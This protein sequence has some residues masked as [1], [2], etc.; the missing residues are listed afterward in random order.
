MLTGTAAPQTPAIAGDALNASNR[1]RPTGMA[2]PLGGQEWWRAPGGRDWSGGGVLGRRR[3]LLVATA[4]G[5]GDGG[6]GWETLT[7]GFRGN[8][9]G[10]G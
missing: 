9:M 7:L 5:N 10:G 6:Q 8:G 3:R 1:R 4:A 2:R